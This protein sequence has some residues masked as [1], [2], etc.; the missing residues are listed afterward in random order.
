MWQS[1]PD[2]CSIDASIEAVSV[3]VAMPTDC[4][5][6]AMAEIQNKHA[7]LLKK[8]GKKWVSNGLKKE[9]EK[10]SLRRGKAKESAEARW[11]HANASKN[12]AVT[13]PKQCSSSST[14][15]P[16]PSTATHT[17][18]DE[19]SVHDPVPI[20]DL[21]DISK[22]TAFIK[23]HQGFSKVNDMA[24]HNVFRGIMAYKDHWPAM[25]RRFQ[26]DFAGVDEFRRPP[27]QE[28]RISFETYIKLKNLPSP[29][30]QA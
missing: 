12:N 13:S 29:H 10:Q 9:A 20:E 26:T 25:V 28:L 5:R 11:R 7:P 30:V 2:Y 24:I 15:S 6:I 1:S 17:K 22:A 3:A 21:K 8:E 19:V 18:E 4:V 16:I 14:P 23:R 27:C